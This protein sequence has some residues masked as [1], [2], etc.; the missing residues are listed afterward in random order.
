MCDKYNNK[1]SDLL[2]LGFDNPE[3][4]WA[5]SFYRDRDPKK[6]RPTLSK[7]NPLPHSWLAI[8][9]YMF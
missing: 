3:T 7:V 4:F 9:I 1:V 6:L 2:D 5:V 8:P